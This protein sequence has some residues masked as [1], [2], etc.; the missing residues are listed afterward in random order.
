MTVALEDGKVSVHAFFSI[1]QCRVSAFRVVGLTVGNSVR[2][3]PGVK[4]DVG[5]SSMRGTGYREPNLNNVPWNVVEFNSFW[6]SDV[7]R[8]H[9]DKDFVPERGY[10]TITRME[11]RLCL[12]IRTD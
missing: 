1:C 6:W 10:C 12:I 8:P 7:P 9:N 3:I 11:C 5:G 4:R 2:I